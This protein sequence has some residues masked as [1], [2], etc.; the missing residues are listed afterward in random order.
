MAELCLGRLP[1]HLEP[2]AMTALALPAVP[3][4]NHWMQASIRL[5]MRHCTQKGCDVR[6]TDG[7]MQHPELW[8]RQSI[9]ISKWIWSAVASFALRGQHINVLELKAIL[10]ES[11]DLATKG[12]SS[13]RLLNRQLVKLNSLTQQMPR[14]DGAIESSALWG[15]PH[16][17]CAPAPAAGKTTG[18]GRFTAD[19][20]Q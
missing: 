13:S 14:R 20:A 3:L 1:F 16:N 8:P 15:H 19:F 12:R 6:L 9:D 11:C 7:S 4:D 17:C 2:Q 5:L 18:L 10:A